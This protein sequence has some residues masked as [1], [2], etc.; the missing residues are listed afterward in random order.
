MENKNEVFFGF[1]VNVHRASVYKD[2]D[3]FL[4]HAYWMSSAV[5]VQT[6]SETEWICWQLL[7]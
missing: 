4:F 5:E 2:K 1:L 6:L 7:G 3:W